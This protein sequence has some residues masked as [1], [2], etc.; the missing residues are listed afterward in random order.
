MNLLIGEN[1]SG[2]TAIIDAIKL[3]ILTESRDYFRLE[4]ED[5]HI[6]PGHVMDEARAKSLKIECIFRGFEDK[7]EEA[8]NFLEWLGI[9]KTAEGIEQYYL[10]VF[11]KRRKDQSKN[12]L[13]C[14]GRSLCTKGEDRSM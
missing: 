8:K 13:W 9:E 3:V 1:D 2:K 5:F 10:S 6:P 7:H 12:L 11:L 14:Q 4:Y